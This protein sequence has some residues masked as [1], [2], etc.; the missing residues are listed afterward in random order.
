MLNKMVKHIKIAGRV[1]GVG[2]RYF[3]YKKADAYNITG[4][5]KNCDD[6][7]VEVLIAGKESD[8]EK[9]VKAISNGPPM[10]NVTRITELNSEKEPEYLE[11]F[12]IHR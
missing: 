2:F 3:A 10:A 12:H 7:S 11:S 9:M 5:V 8:V 6:G 4:W 1:H